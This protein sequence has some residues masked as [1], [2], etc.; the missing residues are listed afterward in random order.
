MTIRNRLMLAGCHAGLD[1]LEVLR[2]VMSATRGPE[3]GL[4]TNSSVELL[5]AAAD[6]LRGWAAERDGYD[7]QADDPTDL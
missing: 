1:Y 3:T 7:T 4:P 2:V 6:R 5:L